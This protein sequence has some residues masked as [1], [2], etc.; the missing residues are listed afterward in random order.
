MAEFLSGT[1][2]CGRIKFSGNTEIRRIAN[3]HCT[4]CQK[5]TGAAFATIIFVNES[6]IKIEGSP[7]I[8]GHI[9]DRGS[10]ME[11]H[12]CSSCGSQ[13]FALNSSRPGL[14]GLRAGS[15]DQKKLVRP[16]VNVYTD[17]KIPLTQVDPNIPSYSKMPE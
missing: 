1:C 13:M 5:A 14:V 10:K 2:L 12:F 4:D 9:S 11:K 8:Y 15:I 7:S 3:C 6:D 17:S 16:E